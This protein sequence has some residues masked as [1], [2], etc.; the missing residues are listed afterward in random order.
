[1]QVRN[2]PYVH[3]LLGILNKNQL[4]INCVLFFFFVLFLFASV[5]HCGMYLKLIFLNLGS[6]TYH[7]SW[8]TALIIMAEACIWVAEVVVY[9]MRPEPSFLGFVYLRNPWP[10]LD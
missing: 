7:K 3:S 5:K 10:N 4:F 1:M 8:L 9:S 6:A 2:I